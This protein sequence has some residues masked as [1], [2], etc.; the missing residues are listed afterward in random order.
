APPSSA[1]C[2]PP[3]R[4]LSSPGGRLPAMCAP[5]GAGPGRQGVTVPDRPDQTNARLEVLH[6]GYVGPRVA[7]TVVYVA[8]G[9]RRIVID[10]SMVAAQSRILDPLRAVG[11]RPDEVTDVVVSHHHP[12]HTINVG[13]FAN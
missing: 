9:D 13:L 4:A 7:S 2:T 1:D 12:D 10:P 11:C 8:D 3:L 6:E 5:P